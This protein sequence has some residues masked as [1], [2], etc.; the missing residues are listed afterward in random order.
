M[1]DSPNAIVIIPDAEA[2]RL[3]IQAADA[4]AGMTEDSPGL[5]EPVDDEG[6]RMLELF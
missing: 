3:G 1:W 2:A 5:V 6:A 4:A